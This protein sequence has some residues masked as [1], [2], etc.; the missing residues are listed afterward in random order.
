MELGDI[1]AELN[2]IPNQP[3]IFAGEDFSRS[4]D[5]LL[6]KTWDLFIQTRDPM[7][8][9]RLPMAKAVVRAMDAI[10]EFIPTIGN[11]PAPKTFLLAG[12][13]KRGW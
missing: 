1:V 8:I 2:Q 9:G 6:A 12:G 10:Q 11:V 3:L 5:S 4:E 7:V 13:S